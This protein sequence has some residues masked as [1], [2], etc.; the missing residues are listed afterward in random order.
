MYILL[1]MKC[2]IKIPRNFFLNSF[3]YTQEWEFLLG[4]YLPSYG[5]DAA[6]YTA[7]KMKFL[8]KIS[9]VNVT[10][11]QKTADLFTFTEEIRDGK[12]HVLCSTIYVQIQ[13]I[14][15]NIQTRLNP[16]LLHMFYGVFLRISSRILNTFIFQN[17]MRSLLKEISKKV[18]ISTI[19]QIVIRKNL[20]EYQ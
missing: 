15:R 1:L 16:M 11:P 3:P 14:L 19:I 8:L 20:L 9:S 17:S 7:Q 4:L 5:L 13:S 18:K 6:I 10:K 12:L 2:K